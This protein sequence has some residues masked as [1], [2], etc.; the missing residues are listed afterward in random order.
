V[1][2]KARPRGISIYRT[3]YSL[4]IGLVNVRTSLYVFKICTLYLSIQSYV[5]ADTVPCT[6]RNLLPL[7]DESAYKHPAPDTDNNDDYILRP[8]L[9]AESMLLPW[10][11]EA[12][13]NTSRVGVCL[14][15][16]V[17]ISVHFSLRDEGSSEY[18]RLC[19]GRESL[20]PNF[21]TFHDPRHQFHGISTLVSETLHPLATLALLHMIPWTFVHS[22]KV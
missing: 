8:V 2:F 6:P 10:M 19:E 4:F 3:S 20:S 12:M 22:L 7:P 1:F 21:Q 17:F 14:R 13:D 18:I 15:C 16:P 5:H 11:K 9:R